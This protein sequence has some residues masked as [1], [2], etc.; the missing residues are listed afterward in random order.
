MLHGVASTKAAPHRGSLPR[1]DVPTMY[2]QFA[3]S[4][5]MTRALSLPFSL[6]VGVLLTAAAWFAFGVA[7]VVVGWMLLLIPALAYLLGL[8]M[9]FACAR[10]ESTLRRAELQSNAGSIRS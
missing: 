9:A 7:G 6:L 4:A 5:P 8:P 2:R 3:P 10:L 1:K